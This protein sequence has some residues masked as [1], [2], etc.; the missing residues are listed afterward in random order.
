DGN[1]QPART[2]ADAGTLP[3]AYRS[4]QVTEALRLADV[5]I[6]DL[7]G[8]ANINDIHT[9]Y[10]SWELRARLDQA[11]GGHANQVIW[12]W[13]SFGAFVRI[14][15]PPD[16]ARTAFLTMDAWLAG[17]ES[18]RSSAPLAAKVVADKPAAAVDACW[19][20]ST[21]TQGGPEVVD[22]GYAGACGQAFPYYGDARQEAGQPLTG[23]V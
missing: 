20:A 21:L 22:P 2:T 1:P 6:I 5:P 10:H 13:R 4:G 19:P 16:I 12:T 23:T 7:R 8:S 15:P 11:H 18:D 17:I 9:D 3:I 14:I